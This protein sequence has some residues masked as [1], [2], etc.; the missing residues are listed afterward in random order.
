MASRRGAGPI[1]RS[2]RSS[3]HDSDHERPTSSRE[4]GILS[5]D[6]STSLVYSEHNY[7]PCPA[8]EKYIKLASRKNRKKPITTPSR[9]T[10]TSAVNPQL[11][12]GFMYYHQGYKEMHCIAIHKLTKKRA[13]NCLQASIPVGCGGV[14]KNKNLKFVKTLYVAGGLVVACCL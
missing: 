3:K 13:C 10:T 12:V 5:V 1:T 6:V 11:L 2:T 7:P 14:A 8:M 9:S 4:E